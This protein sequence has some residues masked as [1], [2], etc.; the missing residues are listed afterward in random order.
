MYQQEFRFNQ[1]PASSAGIQPSQYYTRNM[2]G[3]S[4]HFLAEITEKP[5]TWR[6]FLDK[7]GQ[8][9][10]LPIERAEG[11]GFFNNDR[12]AFNPRWDFASQ[13]LGFDGCENP[14]TGLAF[15]KPDGRPF[16]AWNRHPSGRVCFLDLLDCRLRHLLSFFRPVPLA[17]RTSGEP[18]EHTSSRKTQYDSPSHRRLLAINSNAKARQDRVNGI[19]DRY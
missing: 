2:A 5:A 7:P 17:A 3:E 10:L 16:D 12:I 14:D 4:R 9:R 18:A 15:E 13:R 6:S 19:G 1:S 8:V 11:P